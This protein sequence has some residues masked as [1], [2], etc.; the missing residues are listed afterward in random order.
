MKCHPCWLS[1]CN[2]H[3]DFSDPVQRNRHILNKKWSN[4]IKFCQVKLLQ[5][6]TGNHSADP[7]DHLNYLNRLNDLNPLNPLN[8][9]NFHHL[10][11][12]SILFIAL[13]FQT[14][15]INLNFSWYWI[16][17]FVWLA[18]PNCPAL[19]MHGSSFFQKWSKHCIQ[20]C[21]KEFGTDLRLK[22]T[23]V[24]INFSRMPANVM[25]ARIKLLF[26]L[27]LVTWWRIASLIVW[28]TMWFARCLSP[29]LDISTSSGWKTISADPPAKRF[30][31]HW[32]SIFGNCYG[33]CNRDFLK[34]NWCSRKEHQM[35]QKERP[36]IFMIECKISV[37]ANFDYSWP[38][39]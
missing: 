22:R 21:K 32:M 1:T 10:R 33:I 18:D 39:T 28:R 20:I 23:S 14:K 37:C 24:S 6:L 2:I 12:S 25:Q 3:H 11:F 30:F 38:M 19:L 29:H 36:D 15:W 7:L 8:H 31:N 26:L 5:Q 4:S 34:Q 17:N 9:R 27:R 16:C 13:Y 35:M